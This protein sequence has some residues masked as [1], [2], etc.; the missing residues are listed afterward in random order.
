MKDGQQP[1]RLQ[2]AFIDEQA[3]QCGS[4]HLRARSIEAQ[5][6]LDRNPQAH[7]CRSALGLGWQF[8]PLWRSQPHRARRAACGERGLIMKQTLTSSRRGSPKTTGYVSLAFAIP[9]DAAL[10]QTAAVSAKPR[11][12]G[13]SRTP[14]ANSAHGCA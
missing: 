12:P 13:D 7:R 1:S 3:A 10:S 9:L 2:Q 14:T 11:L 4:P 5:A 8:V 6:L